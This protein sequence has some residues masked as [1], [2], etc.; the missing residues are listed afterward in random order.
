MAVSTHSRS[1]LCGT[2]LQISARIPAIIRQD[3]KVAGRR[4]FLSAF[5]LCAPFQHFLPAERVFRAEIHA[6][7]NRNEVFYRA[8]DLEARQLIEERADQ[9]GTRRI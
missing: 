8:L 2:V 5:W 6:S 3:G 7:S 1:F 4:L 9:A